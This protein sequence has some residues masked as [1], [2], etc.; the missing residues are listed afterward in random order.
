MP[1]DPV[2][3]KDKHLRF[4]DLPIGM[5]FFFHYDLDRCGKGT[6]HLKVADNLCLQGATE[7]I[8]LEDNFL[9]PLTISDSIPQYWESSVERCGMISEEEYKKVTAPY[10]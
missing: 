9:G 8:V 3:K 4:S 1:Y 10:R 7:G 2:I 5:K 6:V